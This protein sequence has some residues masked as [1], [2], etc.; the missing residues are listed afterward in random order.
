MPIDGKFARIVEGGGEEGGD[1]GEICPS[2]ILALQ[3]ALLDSSQRLVPSV[4]GC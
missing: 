4:F 2:Q 1:E 3:T